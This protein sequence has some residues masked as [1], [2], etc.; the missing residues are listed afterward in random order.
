MT[1]LITG[2]QK[3]GKS[4]YAQ[5]LALSFSNNPVYLATS[6]IWDEEQKKRIE[7]WMTIEEEKHISNVEPGSDTVV[8]DCLTLWLTNIFSDTEN[9]A[10]SLDFAKKEIDRIFKKEIKNL[11]IIT[12]EINMGIHPDTKTGRDFVDLQGQMNQY[13]ADKVD[14][15]T[16]MVSGTG[17]VV[18]E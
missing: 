4:A 2:G 10:K 9:V 17:V 6:R 8:L 5:Q 18:K 1:H 14:K 3:S 13:V 12:N 11:I 7:K 16:L 15:V